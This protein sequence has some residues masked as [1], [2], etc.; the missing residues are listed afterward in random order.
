MVWGLLLAVRWMDVRDDGW[1][2]HRFKLSWQGQGREVGDIVFVAGSG[3]GGG[4]GGGGDDAAT[5]DD[6]DDNGAPEK[7]MLPATETTN[8]SAN[9]MIDFR[10]GWGEGGAHIPFTDVMMALISGFSDLA[11]FD[12]D[13]DIS[14]REWGTSWPPYEASVRMRV[15]GAGAVMPVWWTYGVAFRALGALGEW[16]FGK[17]ESESRGAYV[18]VLIDKTAVGQG[19]VFGGGAGAQQ[20]VA[21]S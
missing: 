10:T 19:G 3:G 4:G 6:D 1:R 21:T 11:P 13:E 8:A 7:L 20:E 18:V 2:N 12:L 17:R 16:Y 9:A 15:L 5:V 14:T